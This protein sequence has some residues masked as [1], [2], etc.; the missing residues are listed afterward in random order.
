MS[1]HAVTRVFEDVEVFFAS[2][3][4]SFGAYHANCHGCRASSTNSAQIAG[5][6]AARKHFEQVCHFYGGNADEY[7][8]LAQISPTTN[9][10]KVTFT[11]KGGAQ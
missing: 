3:R 1:A 9:L 6:N 7:S 10:V 5:A 11:R 4:Y 2:T 8:A